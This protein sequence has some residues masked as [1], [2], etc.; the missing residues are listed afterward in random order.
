M[1]ALVVDD[2]KAIRM[3]LAKTL[4][5]IGFKVTEA[6][7]GKEAL[8]KALHADKPNVIL[9]D[10]NMPEMNGLEF[11]QSIRANEIFDDVKLMMVTTE[12]EYDNIIAAKLIGVDQYIVK[13]FTTEIILE[14]LDIM[15]FEQATK[16]LQFLRKI[17]GAVP[18]D[19]RVDDMV[20]FSDTPKS[21]A[22]S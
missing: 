20:A 2:S 18:I 6:V 16:P 7:N 12:S 5:D 13:P 4:G 15:G 22:A 21:S 8:M 19:N 10:W 14:K 9:V 3:I 17:K 1:R 11:V